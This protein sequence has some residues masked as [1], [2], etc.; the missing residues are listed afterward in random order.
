M[1]PGGEGRDA[2]APTTLSVQGLSDEISRH[3][4]AQG[5]RIPSALIGADIR[6]YYMGLSYKQI[7]EGMAARYDF[8]EPSKATI[9]EW[10]RDF[11]DKA[12]EEMANHKATTGDNWV[13]DEMRVDVV[14]EKAWL[15]TV[16]NGRVRYILA[17]HLSRERDTEAAKTVFRKALAAAD[18][19]PAYLFTDK[20]RL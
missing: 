10:V 17:S 1:Q 3:G 5:R 19:P 16:M 6:D 9:Y 7:G 15:G 8:P 4:K 13:A 18:K 11:T 14:G 2:T 20:L 12:V